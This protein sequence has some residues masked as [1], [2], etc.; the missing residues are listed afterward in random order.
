MA[1][2][3]ERQRAAVNFFFMLGKIAT[4]TNEMLKTVYEVDAMGKT[5]MFKWFSHC[6]RGEMSIDDQSRAGRLVKSNIKIWLICF[7]DVR[8]VVHSEFVPPCQTVDQTINMDV[9]KR[10]CN[11]L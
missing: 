9:L 4:E 1:D 2:L 3:H 6:K 7:F 8:G 5:Q 10:L 11:S